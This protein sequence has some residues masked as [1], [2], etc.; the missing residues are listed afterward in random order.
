MTSGLHFQRYFGACVA[1]AAARVLL[2]SRAVR[3]VRFCDGES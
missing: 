3:D 1:L 2:A